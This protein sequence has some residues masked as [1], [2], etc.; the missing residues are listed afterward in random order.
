M[1]GSVRVYMDVLS[2]LTWCIDKWIKKFLWVENIQ[3][4]DKES[5][6][7][8]GGGGYCKELMRKIE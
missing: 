1:T 2:L 8:I 5:N 7:K 4:R 3:V 6:N